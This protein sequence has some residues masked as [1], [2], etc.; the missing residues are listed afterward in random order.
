MKPKR[1]YERLKRIMDKVRE[2]NPNLTET[3]IEDKAINI[4]LGF[5]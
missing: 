3:E 4:L 2:K 1:E 5:E